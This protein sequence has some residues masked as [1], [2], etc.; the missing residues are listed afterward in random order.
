M[1][2][3]GL[4]GKDRKGR[5][6]VSDGA[7]MGPGRAK[8]PWHWGQHTGIGVGGGIHFCRELWERTSWRRAQEIVQ[9]FCLELAGCEVLRVDT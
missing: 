6:D 1:P 4:Q 2:W 9:V 8:R 7:G 3:A 5:A